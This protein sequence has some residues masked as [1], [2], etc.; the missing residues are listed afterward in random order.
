MHDLQECYSGLV[1]IKQPAKQGKHYYKL[2]S[3]QYCSGHP[4]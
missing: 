1:Q 4:S 3:S 2:K